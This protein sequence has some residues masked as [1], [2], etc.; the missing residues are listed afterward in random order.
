[1]V[2]QKFSENASGLREILEK[3]LSG[4]AASPTGG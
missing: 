4:S 2:Y 1:M 3:E